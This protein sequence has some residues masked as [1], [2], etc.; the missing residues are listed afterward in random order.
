MYLINKFRTMVQT[1]L[2]NIEGLEPGKIIS[3]DLIKSGV[4]HYGYEVTTSVSNKSIGYDNDYIVINVTGYLTTKGG[5]LEDFDKYTDE[6]CNALSK[7]NIRT[8]TK[9][10]TTYDTTRKTMITGSVILNTLDKMLR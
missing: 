2:N 9:D 6:I 7:L 10:I 8:T 1:E 4:Y 3:D 5:S